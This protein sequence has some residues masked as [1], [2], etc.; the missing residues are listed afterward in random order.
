MLK[1][2]VLLLLAL[3]LLSAY[4]AY[5][6]AAYDWAE[7]EI[8]YPEGEDWVYRYAYRYPVLTDD[9]P[10]ANAVNAWF[11][12]AFSEMNDLILPMFAA[13]ADMVGGGSNEITQVYDV[14]CNTDDF[15]GILLTQTQFMGEEPIVSLNGQVF[16]MSGEYLGETLTLRGLLGVGESSVQIAEAVVLD[17]YGKVLQLPGA[18]ELWPDADAFYEDFDPETQFYP[19]EQGN[20]VFY[21]QPGMLEE[22]IEPLTFT[23]T[24][25]QAENLLTADAGEKENLP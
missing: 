20:A 2:V 13:E 11:E 15:F 21:L 3:M 23:Y 19:D 17:V 18:G 7:G 22:V 14:T 10:A 16:A 9:T 12:V 4:P 8:T 25:Q 6:G 5:A 1:R 24:A